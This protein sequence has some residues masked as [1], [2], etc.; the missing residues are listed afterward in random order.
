[1]KKTEKLWPLRPKTI[2]IH[3]GGSLKDRNIREGIN[4]N[5]AFP[6]GTV[7]RARR[8]FAGEE[9]ADSYSRISNPTLNRLGRRLAALEGAEAGLVTSSG[10]AAIDL[11][12]K[13]FCAPGGH[14]ISS[15]R[16]YGGTYHLFSE[17][18]PKLGITVTLLE[19]PLDISAW[20]AVSTYK[21][22]MFY[23]ET[24][25]NPLIEIFDV[26]K[27][28][29]VARSH[30]IP[31]VVD[32]T[33]ATPALLQ[34]LSCGADVVIHSISK[35]A[36]SGS[37]IGGAILG[38][39]S[40]IDEIQGGWFR[41]TG[42]CNQP[43]AAATVLLH[44]ES[45]HARMPEHCTNAEMLCSFFEKHPAVRRVWYPTHSGN[46]AQNRILMP[47]GFGGLFSIELKGGGRAARQ[48]VEH[49]TLGT[50]AANIGDAHT[51]AIVPGYTTHAKMSKH[52]LEKIGITPGTVRISAGREDIDD[53]F[54]DFSRALRTI[55]K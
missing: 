31:L 36:S 53:L 28:A 47:C 55:K 45:L 23:V 14:I 8:I 39:Q 54:E 12:A 46:T 5:G 34:P 49:L 25:S 1:M 18:L 6:L 40:L 48:M 35:Y 13:Y 50:H 30:G 38:K 44:L 7:A 21:T 22:K 27:I 51:F 19:D 24:P 43:T 33:L 37:I 52:D 32:S 17:L 4:Q 26:A 20:R 11:I 42:P 16:L 10:M 3:G 9:R 29:E 41:E 2:D 15:N